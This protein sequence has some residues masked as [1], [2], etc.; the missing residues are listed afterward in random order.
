MRLWLCRKILAV[1][2]DMQL[3]Q[4]EI[5]R[6]GRSRAGRAGPASICLRQVQAGG[7]HFR[8]AAM[9][10]NEVWWEVPDRKA[11]SWETVTFKSPGGIMGWRPSLTSLKQLQIKSAVKSC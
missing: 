11:S 3:Q 2:Q 8:T 4:E 5:Y 9:L 10:G 1:L 7:S 6:L